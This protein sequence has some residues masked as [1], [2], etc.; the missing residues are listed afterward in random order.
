M[1]GYGLVPD[2]LLYDRPYNNRGRLFHLLASAL[3]GFN[4]HD[5]A[6]PPNW[7]RIWQLRRCFQSFRIRSQCSYYILWLHDTKNSNALMVCLALSDQSTGLRLSGAYGQLVQKQD[8]PLR[9]YEPYTSRTSISKFRLCCLFRD[10]RCSDRSNQAHRG[11]VS[12]I[13][14]ILIIDCLV[15][16]WHH[17]GMV[18][19][20]RCLDS[21]LHKPMV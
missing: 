20:V 10:W 19:P 9:W 8:Y 15:E 4:L 3:L 7:R 5:S 17:L 14:I 21:A 11:A 2:S 16:F 18:D 1:P 13:T 12:E 6:S